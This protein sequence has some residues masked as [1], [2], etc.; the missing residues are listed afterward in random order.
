M[1]GSE[2]VDRNI[3]QQKRNAMM[4]LLLKAFDII[5]RLTYQIAFDGVHRV[6]V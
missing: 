1:G 5:G 6:V 2:G 3:A 4:N